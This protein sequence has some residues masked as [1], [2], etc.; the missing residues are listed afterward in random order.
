[1]KKFLIHNPKKSKEKQLQLQ[2]GTFYLLIANFSATQ[3]IG[4]A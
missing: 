2:W 1:M 3:N 4:G